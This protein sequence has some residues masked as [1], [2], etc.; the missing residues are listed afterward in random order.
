MRA[1][2]L[3]SICVGLGDRK[4]DFALVPAREGH[5]VR[6]IH[7]CFYPLR[8]LSAVWVFLEIFLIES[9]MRPKAEKGKTLKLWGNEYFVSKKGFSLI[10][11]VRVIRHKE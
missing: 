6:V 3:C 10:H 4:G 11:A 1:Q 7:C 9:S 8:F 2:Q 5:R